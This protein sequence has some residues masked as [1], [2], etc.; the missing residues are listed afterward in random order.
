VRSGQPPRK[1]LLRLL[2]G[3][4]AVVVAL[5]V[6]ATPARAGTAGDPHTPISS[7]GSIGAAPSSQ[8]KTPG[9]AGSAG[10][11]EAGYSGTGSAGPGGDGATHGAAPL[12]PGPGGIGVQDVFLPD[13]R[14]RVNPT[15]T[16]PFRA[17]VAITRTFDNGLTYSEWCTGWMYAPDMVATAGHCVHDG[18]GGDWLAGNDLRIVPAR[19]GTLA[20][21]GFCTVRRMHTVLG[22]SDDGKPAFD[23][24]AIT[25]NCTVGNT[26]G[27]YGWWW[28]TAS[29][30]GLSTT[31][32]GYPVDQAVGTQWRHADQ[33]RVTQDRRI[34]YQND[35][36]NG[37]S[38]SAVYQNRAAGSA[39]CTGFCSM[40]IHAYGSNGTN[41]SGT[42]ITEQV[43]TNLKFWRDQL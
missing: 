38:G 36:N 8:Q 34:F 39:F 35:T 30:T 41:N 1:R 20:P 13:G 14:V 17:N 6:A 18:S 10:T 19:N 42:R 15:T 26:V 9:S 28:Q 21:Y 29:L 27:W 2:A 37:Q 33:V 43:S 5:G 25:L 32:S 4:A 23:Y 24:G 7:D 3:T 16:Y 31:I 22:W 11:G 40:G 12:V